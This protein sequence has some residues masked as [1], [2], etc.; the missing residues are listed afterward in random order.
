MN[1]A[2][3]LPTDPELAEETA[4][5]SRGQILIMFAFFAAAMFG[6][7]GL[8]VDLGMSFAQRRTMQNAADLGAIAGARA[9]ARYSVT[10]KTNALADVQ[11]VVAGNS[12]KNGNTI[13]SCRYRDAYGVNL[14]SCSAIVPPTAI[15]VEVTV[16][17]NHPTYFIR[18]FPGAPANVTTR[19]TARAEV[20]ALSSSAQTAN[21]SPFI[22][23]GYGT[24]I[25]G[26]IL[27]GSNLPGSNL[28][29]SILLTDSTVNPLAVGQKFV[30]HGSQ[31][32]GCGLGSNDFKGL[33]EDRTNKPNNNGKSLNQ[34]WNAQPGVHAGPTRTKVNAIGGC[35]LNIDPSGCVMMIPVASDDLH[36]HPADKSG[37]QSKLYI[38][39]V[40][41]FWVDQC[42]SN[43]HTATLLD[44]YTAWGDSV[45]RSWT[46][47][48]NGIIV[49]KLRE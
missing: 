11:D 27:P 49:I 34:Y 13:D 41:A 28:P 24:Q 20:E 33:A 23:C 18:I 32:A 22:I 6:M 43:C 16:S 17:E 25:Y 26:S 5:A 44:D 2:R 1:Q 38:V 7:L 30:V 42:G 46:R 8:A 48:S 3:H 9:V 29:G 37:S 12:M 31:V 36:G 40:L 45:Q 21:G 35:G 19:A 47:D 39:K 14:V 4:R 15:G 10:N